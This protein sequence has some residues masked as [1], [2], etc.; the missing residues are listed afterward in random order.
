M[1][2]LHRIPTE[3]EISDGN[4]KFKFPSESDVNSVE[5]KK[6]LHLVHYTSLFPSTFSPVFGASR[7]FCDNKE[8]MTD[9][10]EVADGQCIYIGNSSIAAVKGKGKI[11]LK[12]TSRKMLSLSN[13]LFVPSLRRNLISSTLLDV[14]GLKIMQEDGKVV[15]M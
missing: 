3:I 10:E 8:L 5:A 15:I 4:Q 7:H 9:F 14:A 11:L 6:G 12:F 13:V 1:E 2:F